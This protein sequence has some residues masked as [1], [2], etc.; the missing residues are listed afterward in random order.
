M[1]KRFVYFLQVEGCG[2]VKIG[3]ALKPIGRLQSLR[4]WCPYQLDLIATAPGDLAQEKTLHAQFAE[5]R[6]HYEWYAPHQSLMDLIET[7]KETGSLPSNIS[8]QGRGLVFSS[9]DDVC[10]LFGG[11]AETAR[12]LDI[13]ISAISQWKRRASIPPRSMYRLW[14]LARTQ[15]LDTNAFP[16]DVQVDGQRTQAIQQR[17]AA[18]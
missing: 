9:V 1:S 3:C 12:L 17:I 7:V 15:G 11:Q 5:H 16:H 2:P 4:A 18:Q 6:L 8:T 13:D 14:R 10:E